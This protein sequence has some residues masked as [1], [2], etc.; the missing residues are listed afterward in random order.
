MKNVN[1][2]SLVRYNANN[3]GIS[4]GDCVKRAISYA[5]NKS[6]NDVSKLLVAEEKKYP[7]LTWKNT[8]VFSEVISQLYGSELKPVQYDGQVALNDF[9]DE[10]P[11]GTYIFT[12]GK[13]SADYSSH[14][15]CAVDGKVYDSWD[16]RNWV[17]YKCWTIKTDKEEVQEYDVTQ[18]I[19]DLR[20]IAEDTARKY[21]E[22]Y[23][24]KWPWILEGFLDI[25]GITSGYKIKMN[26]FNTKVRYNAEYAIVFNP[27]TT[28]DEALAIIE[29]TTKIRLYDRFYEKNKRLIED[30]KEK[31]LRGD[32]PREY[33]KYFLTEQERKFMASL[34]GWVRGLATYVNIQRPNQY[35]DSYC[36]EI[37][38]KPGDTRVDKIKF[39]AYD[40]SQMKDMLNRYWEKG[41]IPWEDYNVYEEY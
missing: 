9:V 33:E 2:A 40:S 32:T 35:S 36:V 38:P 22:K 23:G 24:A 10:H 41:E 4:T 28:E 25:E 12:V 18:H 8:I 15:V 6:Y 19:E 17:I 1:S 11:T 26:V 3:R 13:P 20:R 34:P 16:S 29:N 14:L 27:R 21:C 31:E 7:Y 39:E 37:K 5:F 30:K